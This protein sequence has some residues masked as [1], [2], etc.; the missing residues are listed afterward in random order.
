MPNNIH[1]WVEPMGNLPMPAGAI[2]AVKELG[3]WAR[4]GQ[5]LWYVKSDLTSTAIRDHVR[6]HLNSTDKL[7]V[8]DATNGHAAWHG[9]SPDVSNFIVEK[10]K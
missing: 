1:I 9:L 3:G 2:A 7:Y 4:L 10:W 5:N 6:P 8:L